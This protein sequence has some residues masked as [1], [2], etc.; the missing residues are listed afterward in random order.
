MKPVRDGSQH[1]RILALLAATPGG[2][3]TV[4]IAARLKLDHNAVSAALSVLFE[5]GYVTRCKVEREGMRAAL[6]YRLA[7]GAGKPP[8]E[9]GKVYT[10]SARPPGRDHSLPGGVVVRSHAGPRSESTGRDG[11]VASLT[12]GA[13]S[14]RP[15][16]PGTHDAPPAQFSAKRPVEPGKLDTPAS[17]PSGR[18]PSPVEVEA[19]APQ[20]LLREAEDGRD[21]GTVSPVSDGRVPLR[22]ALYSDGTLI[23]ENLPNCPPIVALPKDRT[24]EL[25]DY[26]LSF[27]RGVEA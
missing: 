7:S 10:P 17:R 25:V 8:L 24:R 21:G 16:E 26:L 22:C 2:M 14:K 3:F 4:D 27:K 6:Q 23:L 20:P 11:G 5:R 1:E 15:V 19:G 18:P 9:T 12:S 13:G